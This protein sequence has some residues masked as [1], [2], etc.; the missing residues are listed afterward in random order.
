MCCVKLVLIIYIL[1]Y[2]KYFLSNFVRKKWPSSPAIVFPEIRK[3]GSYWHNIS[4]FCATIT[5]AT[6]SM[7]TPVQ[8]HAL[9]LCLVVLISLFY[10]SLMH[11]SLLREHYTL[12]TFSLPCPF[13]AARAVTVFNIASLQGEEYI[14]IIVCKSHSDTLITS[15]RK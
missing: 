13:P 2:K 5:T 11:F 4:L 1:I 12:L 8:V 14:C 3:P 9:L 15:L 6:A 7:P 10:F